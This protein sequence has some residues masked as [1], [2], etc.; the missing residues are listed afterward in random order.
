MDT[1]FRLGQQRGEERRE[2]GRGRGRGERERGENKKPYYRILVT[3]KSPLV[4][5]VPRC[6]AR[7]ASRPKPEGASR[8]TIQTS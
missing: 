3:P 7:G 6:E 8:H 4:S 1:H 5:G 2:R